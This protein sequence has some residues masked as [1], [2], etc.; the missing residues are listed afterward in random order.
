MKNLT[1][2]FFK[3]TL[4][5]SMT[6]ALAGCGKKEEASDAQ[7]KAPKPPDMIEYT[8]SD[9]STV[10]VDANKLGVKYLPTGEIFSY[11]YTP[12]ERHLV[13]K[14][15]KPFI[16]PVYKH[17][18]QMETPESIDKLIT[19]FFPKTPNIATRRKRGMEDVYV[20]LVSTRDMDS[21][22]ALDDPY[23]VI[24]MRVVYPKRE[25]RETVTQERP[26][27]TL[28][29]S[30]DDQI[31]ALR[32]NL[33]RLNDRMTAEDLQIPERR[34]MQIQIAML[35]DQLTELNKKRDSILSKNTTEQP[36][37]VISETIEKGKKVKIKIVSFNIRTEDKNK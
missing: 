31:S 35:E 15:G 33:A 26:D 14:L 11:S 13:D 21:I 32:N 25:K 10:K 19:F 18:L 17:E 28:T 30:I 27:S 16:Q 37:Q 7:K 34:R 29:A 24:D 36:N 2:Y 8:L 5:L 1:A 6:L 12:D 22:R 9:G 4:L 3:L 23:V 20:R